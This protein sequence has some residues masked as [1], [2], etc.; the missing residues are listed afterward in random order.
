MFLFLF[1]NIGY[2]R[3]R[4]TVT[5]PQDTNEVKSDYSYSCTRNWGRAWQA[6]LVEEVKADKLAG[7]STRDRDRESRKG[8]LWK[9]EVACPKVFSRVLVMYRKHHHK[10]WKEI[11]PNILRKVNTMPALSS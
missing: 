2:Q 6:L 10:G 9:Y 11:V 5:K 1:L 4:I 8:E 7:H 3:E